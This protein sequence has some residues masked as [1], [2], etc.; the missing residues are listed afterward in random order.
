MLLLLL[1][2]LFELELVVDLELAF[3]FEFF[4]NCLIVRFFLV[5]T[6]DDEDDSFD[7]ILSRLLLRHFLIV[8]GENVFL[9]KLNKDDWLFDFDMLD[10]DNCWSLCWSILFVPLLWLFDSIVDDELNVDE[11]LE[12]EPVEHDDGEDE[13]IEASGRVFVRRCF[14]CWTEVVSFFGNIGFAVLYFILKRLL[15]LKRQM[16]L[17]DF[18]RFFNI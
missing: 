10:V 2:L 8:N 18:F 1:L 6:W 14:F 7:A 15:K 13:G 17:N 4:F 12:D 3:S 9:N 5:S 16:N 11:L